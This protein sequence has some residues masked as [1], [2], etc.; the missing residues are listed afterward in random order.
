MAGDGRAGDWIAGNGGEGG[1]M[2]GRLDAGW[3]GRIGDKDRRAGC[4][5]T[6]TGD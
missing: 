4:G 2:R 1:W 6:G 5:P 3:T